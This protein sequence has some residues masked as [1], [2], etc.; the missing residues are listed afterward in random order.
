MFFSLFF[1]GRFS[2]TRK[3]PQY[4][5]VGIPLNYS[6]VIRNENKTSKRGLVLIDEL[7]NQFPSLDHFSQTT[8]PL[9]KKSNRIDRFIGYPRLVNVMQKLR[10]GSIKPI[11]VDYIAEQSELET[12]ISDV[13]DQDQMLPQK[14]T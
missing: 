1:R 11:A 4:G 9:D 7:K 12:T 5:S 6:C 10:G 8:Y 2:I 14:A 13:V 3:L